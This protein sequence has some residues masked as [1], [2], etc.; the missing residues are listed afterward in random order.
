MPTIPD[1]I[2]SEALIAAIF[3]LLCG[4]G[5]LFA[6]F[7]M[8][9]ASQERNAKLLADTFASEGKAQRE[10]DKEMRLEGHQTR[11]ESAKLLASELTGSIVAG[12][13]DVKEHHAANFVIMVDS[14]NALAKSVE[15]LQT[16]GKTAREQFDAKI[17]SLEAIPNLQDRL[18]HL[19]GKV[20]N[21]MTEIK[22]TLEKILTELA[23]VTQEKQAIQAKVSELEEKVIALTQQADKAITQLQTIIDK[24]QK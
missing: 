12:F 15:G 9:L 23:K 6:I 4:G 7:K 5:F 14:V 11:M 24:E 19:E 1:E 13:K 20:E 21:G 3:I 17:K 22:E 10:H 8:M 18:E 2:K 16:E